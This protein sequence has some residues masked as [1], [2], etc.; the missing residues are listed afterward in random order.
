MVLSFKERN[1]QTENSSGQFFKKKHHIEM[2]ATL[3]HFFDEGNRIRIQTGQSRFILN[4]G[5]E[6]GIERMQTRG[7]FG[8]VDGY[9]FLPSLMR[10]LVDRDMLIVTNENMTFS[11]TARF[12]VDEAEDLSNLLKE[13][14]E[15]NVRSR[16]R[17]LMGVKTALMQ[18]KELNPD[19]LAHI[20]SF[21]TGKNGTLATQTNELKQNLGEQLAPRV[22]GRRATRKRSTVA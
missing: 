18:H 11:F 14:F 16:G 4:Y 7:R 6:I 20:A 5:G 21:S 9:F 3:S 2:A 13:K 22:R 10:V 19:V 15:E 1:R 12:S 17:N 8:M